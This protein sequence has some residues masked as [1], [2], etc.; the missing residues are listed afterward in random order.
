MFATSENTRR[1]L[2]SGT[3]AELRELVAPVQRANRPDAS[4]CDVM[5]QNRSVTASQVAAG[6][7]RVRA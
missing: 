5:C 1:F 4:P 7:L 6:L 2:G 3:V